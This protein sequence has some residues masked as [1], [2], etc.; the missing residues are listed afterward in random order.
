MK[1]VLFGTLVLMNSVVFASGQSYV[2][3]KKCF[4]DKE[5][6]ITV[7]VADEYSKE[8]QD[9]LVVIGYDK[10]MGGIRIN[11]L[12]S[13]FSG[14]IKI[15]ESSISFNSEVSL[16]EGFHQKIEMHLSENTNGYLSGTLEIIESDSMGNSYPSKLQL[17]N[18]E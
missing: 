3:I 1:S 14:P 13:A 2:A 15:Q 17:S 12:D 7:L 4:A 10:S 9:G 6:V 18:C 5:K 16:N 11:G 8:T